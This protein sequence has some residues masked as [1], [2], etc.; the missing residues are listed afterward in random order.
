M[1]SYTDDKLWLDILVNHKVV[2]VDHKGV[3]V[4]HKGVYFYVVC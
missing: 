1:L 2:H 3:H 4:D